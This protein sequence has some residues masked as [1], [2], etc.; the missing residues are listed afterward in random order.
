MTVFSH[1][2]YGGSPNLAAVYV[3]TGA[4]LFDVRQF[5]T[6]SDGFEHFKRHNRE[7]V[8]HIVLRNKPVIEEVFKESHSNSVHAQALGARN[9]LFGPAH[10]NEEGMVRDADPRP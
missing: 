6:E 4:G 2:N 3:K 10:G 1:S 9:S 5:H 8:V 7:R